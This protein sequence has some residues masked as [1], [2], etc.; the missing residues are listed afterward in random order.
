VRQQNGGTYLVFPWT[1]NGA[2]SVPTVIMSWDGGTSGLSLGIVDDGNWHHHAITWKQNT[3]SGFRTFR[4]GSLVAS[5]NAANSGIPNIG[6]SVTVGQWTS[7]EGLVGALAHVAVY[8]RALS[9]GE[10]ATRY[11]MAQSA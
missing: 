8:K 4:D 2:N 1:N 11:A 7:G 6:V 9:D 10:I 3:T 5:R